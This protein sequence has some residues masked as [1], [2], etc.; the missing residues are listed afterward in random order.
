MMSGEQFLKVL[1]QAGEVDLDGAQL[2]ARTAMMGAVMADQLQD[3]VDAED[4]LHFGLEVSSFHA[5]WSGRLHWLVVLDRGL[6]ELSAEIK[7]PQG[8]RILTTSVVYHHYDDIVTLRESLEFVH[9]AGRDIAAQ[10]ATFSIAF[11]GG[12][13]LEVA[14]SEALAPQLIRRLYREVLSLPHV[15]I[16]PPS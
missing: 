1:R 16:E 5:D 6:V 10:G 2:T 13:S 9:I 14:S 15:S 3:V 11:E 4:S 8:R 7:E 12:E